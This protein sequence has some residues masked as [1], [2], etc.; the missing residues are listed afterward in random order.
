MQPWPP[1]TMAMASSPV[2]GVPPLGYPPPG[3]PPGDPA[4]MDT[5]PA[6]ST[7]DLLATAGVGRGLRSPAVGPRTPTAPGPH[8][9]QPSA[10]QQW[11]PTS[12]RYEAG[13]ATLTSSRFICLGTPLGHGWPPPRQTLPLAPVRVAMRWPE[14]A[15]TPKVGPHPKGL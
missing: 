12:G 5:L 6:P 15:K 9:V 2:S 1:P 11:M 4:L 10:I 8:Q 7:G 3:L 13:Q 14:G